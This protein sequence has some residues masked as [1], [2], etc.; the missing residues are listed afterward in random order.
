MISDSMFH[1]IATL[2]KHMSVDS[3]IHTVTD[4]I[5]L[6]CYTGFCKSEWCSDHQDTFDTIDDPNW[7][8][9]PTSLPVNA[10]NFSFATKTGRQVHDIKATHNNTI[11]FTLLGICKQ[12][13]NDNGQL[14]KYLSY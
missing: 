13:K 8:D 3:F 9:R 10:G 1:H 2:Y 7:G 5:I 14:L 12:K 6:R 11:A 4:W